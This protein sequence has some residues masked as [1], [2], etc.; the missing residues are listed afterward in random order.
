[1]KI[2]VLDGYTVNP[3]DLDWSLFKE[4]GELVVYDRTAYG[5][6]IERSRGVDAVLTNKTPLD[7]FILS[8]LPDL[9]YIGVLATGYNIVDTVAA[10][11]RGIIVANA[12]AYSTYSVVQMTFALLFELSLHCQKHS[13]A[14]YAGKWSKS[15]DFCFWD[16]P[17][18]ELA[19]KTMGIIGFGDIG[20]KVADVATALGMNIIAVS[21]SRSDQSA[22]KNFQWVD[23]QDLLHQSDVISI[24]S[25]L[26]P[27]TRG[28]IN[29]ASLL[30]MKR[31]A[32]LIN[33]SR[34]PIIVE[35]DLANALNTGMIA[36]AGLDVLSIEPPS[37]DNP[38]FK[39]KNCIVTPHIAWATKESRTRLMNIALNN[40]SA[41][42]RGHPENVVSPMN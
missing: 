7:E 25:P 4:L 36:G 13:D 14:V 28:M 9:K 6:I 40:L 42:F 26:T 8:Q 22:R 38:I 32:F 20:Q 23:W 17:L 11:K 41:F 33:T 21:R 16:F 37:A 3:G 5:D 15:P 34:G 2:V 10:G 35:E 1:M 18:V 31:S 29:K 27:E 30:Q 39:A 24:H 19:G 12:P